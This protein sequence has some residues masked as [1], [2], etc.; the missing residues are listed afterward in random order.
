[1]NIPA[2]PSTQET[3]EETANKKMIGNLCLLR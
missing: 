2:S 1:M 3:G